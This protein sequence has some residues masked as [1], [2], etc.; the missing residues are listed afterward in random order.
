MKKSD[1]DCENEGFDSTK[2]ARRRFIFRGLNTSLPLVNAIDLCSLG[3]KNGML[4]G[5][6][7]YGN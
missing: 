5:L 7:E 4:S 6:I 1:Y 2:C 3:L